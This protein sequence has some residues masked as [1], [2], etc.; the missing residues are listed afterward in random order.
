ME[1]KQFNFLAILTALV[2]LL[3]V[4]A[5]VYAFVS[6]AATWQEFSGAIGPI[7]GMFAGYWL[8]GTQ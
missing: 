8:K 1:S 5:S 2:V 3:Y 7:A 6:N 4:G